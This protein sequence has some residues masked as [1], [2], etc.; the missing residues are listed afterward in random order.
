[1]IESDEIDLVDAAPSPPTPPTPSSSASRTL[2]RAGLIVSGA[3]LVSRLLGFVRQW[4]IINVFGAG[5]E[6]DQFFA[7]F[8]LPDLIF[9]LVAAGALASS[10]VPI[11]SGLLGHGETSRAWR[12]TSTIVNLLLGALIAL[13]ILGFVFAPAIVRAITPGFDEAGWEKTTE[14]TRIML[15]SPIF[16]AIGA[17]ASS[18]LNAQGR[19]A[20]S[21]AA[22]VVYNL[23]IIGGALIL[24][25]SLGVTGLAISV[26]A[27]SVG[28]L[29]VQ[30]PNVRAIGYRY[31]PTV[32]LSDMA[33]RRALALMGPRTLGLGVTQITFVVMTSLA[34]TVQAGALTAFNT[35]FT[36]LQIPLGLIGVPLGIVVLPS[37]SREMALG[38]TSEFAGLVSRALRLILVAMLPLT[39]ISLV[40]RQDIVTLLFGHGFDQ[41]A[42]D[43]TTAA[44]GAFLLGLP[45]HALIGI[46]ARTFYAQQDTRTPVIAAIVA[47]V[48]NCSL[49]FVLVGP[50]GLAGLSLAIA[51]AAWIE[52]GLLVVWL[53]RRIP[54]LTFAP[55]ARLGAKALLV[56]AIGSGAALLVATWLDAAQG[57][58]P[59]L[60]ALFA[61]MAVATLVW[62]AVT[63]GA[64]A[65]LRIEELRSIVGLMVDVLRRPRRS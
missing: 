23:A 41:T 20:A 57:P 30:L 1:V 32:D 52:T 33:A 50:L 36:L 38:H 2:A 26:V 18:I 4:I 14:L 61:R 7:A 56:A 34:T 25:P 65:V 54:A 44:F 55:I 11:I 24:G 16:L 59:G 51:I 64:A 39:G 22:P 58:D 35:A 48:I 15:L 5:P 47:V 13:A 62:A 40:L 60:V 53:L 17:I 42:I 29:L 3:F 9:Q 21:A 19:F 43:L 45:A 6:L 8:R 12:V 27:G 37:L 28:H 10:V 31:A 49:A 63:V 46:L